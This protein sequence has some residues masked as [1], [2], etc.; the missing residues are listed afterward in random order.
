MTLLSYGVFGTARAWRP[1]L[2]PIIV[3]TVATEPVLWRRYVVLMGGR[4]ALFLLAAVTYPVSAWLA[5]GLV[6]MSLP[7]RWMAVLIANDAPARRTEDTHRLSGAASVRQLETRS[8]MI[9]DI[10][11]NR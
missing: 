9:V 7:L 10:P 4:L 1:L 2:D 5:V 8:H 11:E 6:A 3:D